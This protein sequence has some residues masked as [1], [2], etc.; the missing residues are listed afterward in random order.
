MVYKGPIVDFSEP[1]KVVSMNEII[2]CFLIA[3]IFTLCCFCALYIKCCIDKKIKRGCETFDSRDEAWFDSRGEPVVS[4]TQATDASYSNNDVLPFN[5]EATNTGAEISLNN[6][7]L[8]VTEEDYESYSIL[9]M[10]CDSIQSLTS[11]KRSDEDI[12]SDLEDPDELD[13]THVSDNVIMEVEESRDIEAII[14]YELGTEENDERESRN[15][16][17]DR[18]CILNPW[19]CCMNC[20]GIISKSVRKRPTNFRVCKIL[21]CCKTQ[22]IGNR[23]FSDCKSNEE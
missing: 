12:E 15:C 2:V 22:V 3:A 9:G 14:E 1:V 21:C 19:T 4:F 7:G 5:E 10:I 16:C 20:F 6:D 8:S 11:R 18:T 17:L 23:R 13:S